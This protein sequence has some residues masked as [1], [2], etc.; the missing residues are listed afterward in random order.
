MKT[1]EIK[2]KNILLLGYGR[3][4]QSVHRFLL[5]NY[6]GITIDIADKKSDPDYLTRLSDY[7]TVI[8]SPGIPVHTKELVEYKLHGGHIT[9]ATNIF[10]SLCPGITIGITGTKGKSTTSALIAHILQTTKYD[11]RLV[12][13]IGNPMLNYLMVAPRVVR[14]GGPPRRGPLVGVLG[15]KPATGPAENTI[16][17]IE[18]S[19]HQLEDCRYS[20]H[21]AVVL[22]IF[23]EHMDYYQTFDQYVT[24]KTNIV[25]FQSAKDS[26]VYDDSNT[27][28][29][30]IA[31]TSKGQKI[32]ISLY[33]TT[34][35]PKSSLIG[36]DKNIRAALAAASLLRIPAPLASQAI[37][38]F[39]PLS[40]RLEFVG[41]YKKIK[42]YND[43]L[44]TIPEATI[45]AIESLGDDVTT[46]I[47]GGYDRG[48]DYTALGN[49]LAKRKTL[50]TLILFPDTGE[51]I[52]DA[53]LSAPPMSHVS[54][55]MSHSMEAAV[56]LAYAHTPP[57]TI[58][59]LS[60]ASASYNLF[61]DYA[62]RG[63]QFK[64]WVTKLGHE[65]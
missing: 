44:A 6:P 38:T 12:G 27:T 59:L 23:P 31:Q 24:A 19:S 4:N 60:P 18:L 3:E 57:G 37:K 39:Q 25:A 17:V 10:F 32:P 36:N 45:H 7:D 34:P 64:S 56:S 15:G 33:K 9:T 40:H 11:V 53:L 1:R 2:G 62:D 48:L 22:N 43:S 54:C 49:F 20:P 55:L 13:N 46:L 26:V 58:C 47:A 52:K 42:F 8:R 30:A 14:G 41:E 16:F 29:A 35:I 61:K 51:K 28:A 65:T 50:K 21:I 5:A 63:E